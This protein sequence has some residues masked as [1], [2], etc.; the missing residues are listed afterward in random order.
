MTE[1][2]WADV[3]IDDLYQGDSVEDFG[4]ILD[5]W[6]FNENTERSNCCGVSECCAPVYKPVTYGVRFQGRKNIEIW[7][8]S[9]KVRAYVDPEWTTV[10]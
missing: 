7:E 3:L 2:V 4:V 9:K 10:Q 1:R 5:I 6:P 8:Y